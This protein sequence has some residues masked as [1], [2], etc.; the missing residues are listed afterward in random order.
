MLAGRKDGVHY[1]VINAG[2]PGWSLWDERNFAL[3]TCTMFVLGVVLFGSTVLMPIM[4]QTLL[5]YTA[6][7]SGLVLSPGGLVVLFLMPLVGRL[8]GLPSLVHE[9][10]E[11]AWF[12]QFC[13][14]PMA[15]GIFTGSGYTKNFGRRHFRYRGLGALAYLAD[16]GFDPTYGARPQAG[17]PEGTEARPCVCPGPSGDTTVGSS[18]P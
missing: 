7:L 2:V 14:M 5:G 10:T 11:H 6:T 18:A 12:Q 17:H 13:T 16:A 15:T 4:L 9:D 1:E 3:A 8:L